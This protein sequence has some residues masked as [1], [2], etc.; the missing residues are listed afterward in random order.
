MLCFSGSAVP[1]L[2][3]RIYDAIYA[4]VRGNFIKKSLLRLAY[5]SKRR[6]LERHVIQTNTI[7]DWLV[8]NKVRANLGGRVRLI[9]VGSAPLSPNV[10]DF[11]RCA[12]GCVVSDEHIRVCVCVCIYT[13]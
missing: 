11:L 2:L 8:F 12:L 9:C 6:D 5:Q 10:L 1:R 13:Y 4:K 7:W 3:N